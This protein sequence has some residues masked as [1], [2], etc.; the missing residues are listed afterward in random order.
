MFEGRG[1]TLI[2]AGWLKLVASDQ[3]EESKE[4]EASNPVPKLT[5]GL[6]LE[7]SAGRLLEKKT[8]PPGRYTEASLVKKLESEGIGRPAT[9]A[10][11]MDNIISRGYVRTEKK[12][13]LPTPTGQTVVAALTGQF[14]F[15]ELGYTRNVEA[16]LDLIANGGSTYGAVVQDLYATLQE[17][18]QGLK[19]ASTTNP[20]HPC[21]TCGKALRRMKGGSGF[22]WGCTGYPDCKTTLPDTKGKP[23]A[24]KEVS[25]S[26]HA[27]PACGK[28]LIHRQKKGKGGY[29]FWGCSGFKDGCRQS[30]PNKGGTPQI[31]PQQ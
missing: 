29:D 2:D 13:L 24:R 4:A 20:A 15:V 30:F 28:P 19:V 6:K 7:P 1:R 16:S 12:H 26:E 25:L 14:S 8:K 31:P 21:P 27:C 11:I 22:F 5:E 17:E 3:T 9:Y 10:A 23:G 18:M